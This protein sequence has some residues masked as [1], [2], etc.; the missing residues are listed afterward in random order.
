MKGVQ[1]SPKEPKRHSLTRSRSLQRAASN[2]SDRSSLS[3][4]ASPSVLYNE[5]EKEVD[6][7]DRKIGGSFADD[8]EMASGEAEVTDSQ[9]RPRLRTQSDFSSMNDD[10]TFENIPTASMRET[11][12]QSERYIFGYRIP[13]GLYKMPSTTR[14]ST[15]VVSCAPCFWCAKPLESHLTVR[16]LLM[17]LS[18][19]CG[20][21]ALLQVAS[22][23]FL[24]TVAQNKRIVD[25]STDHFSSGK[26][27]DRSPNLYDLS[28][29]VYF[30]GAL[31][32]ILCLVMFFARRHVRD[33]VLPGLLR[34][35]W[36]ALWILPLEIYAAISLFGTCYLYLFSSPAAILYNS[37]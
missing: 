36:Y 30:A 28:G 25:R 9:A 34:V 18:V 31:A 19:L 22:F 27:E 16:V 32:M 33:V 12:Q 5:D 14:M 23:A 2:S 10:D 21:V 20:F 15:F 1:W 6:R 3:P 17:R 7:D 26:R 13:R 35:M 4:R 8:E 24:M 37:S 29:V 11:M